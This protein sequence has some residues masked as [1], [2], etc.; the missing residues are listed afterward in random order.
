MSYIADNYVSIDD[1]MFMA[2][3]KIPDGLPEE[4]INWLLEAGA[5]H[6]VASVSVT[7]NPPAGEPEDDENTEPEGVQADGDAEPEDVQDDEEPDEPAP[8]IDVMAGIVQS[9]EKPE[10]KPV[11]RA[12]ASTK[13]R[14]TK[15]GKAK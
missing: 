11:R 3:E 5:I 13:K 8:E 10:K 9:E 4:K 1:E 6:K 2:G 7:G 15:G 14:T 12:S